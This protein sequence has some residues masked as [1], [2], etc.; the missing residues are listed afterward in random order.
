MSNGWMLLLC[1]VIILIFVAVIIYWFIRNSKDVIIDDTVKGFYS[2]AQLGQL[3][4]VGSS[5]QSQTI[6]L[7]SFFEAQPCDTGLACIPSS[8]NPDYGYCKSILNNP[9]GNV[10]D[11]AP[12]PYFGATGTIYCIGGYCNNSTFGGLYA[13]CG[14]TG[15]GVICDPT[16]LTC[17]SGNCLY[18]AGNTCDPQFNQCAKGLYCDAGQKI[19]I[20]PIKGGESCDGPYCEAGFVCNSQ[21]TCQPKNRINSTINNGEIGSFCNIP[22][23]GGTGLECKNGLIC[24]FNPA[25]NAPYGHTGSTGFGICEI[26]SISS[27]NICGINNACIPP[28]VCYNEAC[29]APFNMGIEDINYCGPGSSSICGSG[30]ECNNANYACEPKVGNLCSTTYGSTGLCI[31]S[32]CSGNKLGIFTINR[33]GQTGL[34][35]LGNWQYIDLPS[36]E[37]TPPSNQSYLSTYQSM[38]IN[39]SGDPITT[40]RVIYFPYYMSNTG[41]YWYSELE[42]GATGAFN[43][44]VAW[45]QI[46]IA[47]MNTYF[48][49]GVKFTTGGNIT[50]LYSNV[51]DASYASYVNVYNFSA[52]P[53]IDFA[54]PTKGPLYFNTYNIS[55]WDIDDTYNFGIA[56]LVTNIPSPNSVLYAP[57]PN[58]GSATI[59][60]G[61]LT[62]NNT[63][64]V[65]YLINPNIAPTHENVILGTNA[66]GTAF[67]EGNPSINNLQTITLQEPHT[68]GAGFFT[69]FSNNASKMEL[70]YASDRSFRYVNNVINFNGTQSNIDIAFEGYVP[71]YNLSTNTP[72]LP[73]Q[74][75]SQVNTLFMGNIDSRLFAVVSVCE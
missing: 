60:T 20:N 16:N 23:V 15:L 7:P 40:T 28:N 63:N 58:S 22:Y 46:I 50:I 24:T 48:I 62:S 36:S 38:S 31:D 53:T 5:T 11:C 21:G 43:Q 44:S 27:G 34:A 74:A 41:Y 75:V 1:I 55:I 37:T 17:S 57:L 49:Q 6:L 68:N 61:F 12:Q 67:I 29:Q 14:T 42:S 8:T 73:V 45:T 69:T 54:T 66:L 52:S 2:Y 33:T 19:C 10:Y 72:P 4:S 26:P 3:C 9:C 47:N 32:V 65:K 51:G 39:I 59:T 13:S 56:G 35:H 25:I 30:F 18:T 70:Y 64:W 71:E